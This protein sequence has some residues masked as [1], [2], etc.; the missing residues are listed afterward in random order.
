M[1]FSGITMA[2]TLIKEESFHV[3]LPD[4]WTKIQGTS[5]NIAWI[6]QSSNGN[7]RLTVS[8]HYF[9]KEP[10]LNEIKKSIESYILIRQKSSSEINSG[11]SI[12]PDELKEYPAAITNIFF[13]KGP[14]NRN[15]A[16]KT[17]ATKVGIANFYYESYE[18]NS[19]FKEKVKTIL[20]TTGFAS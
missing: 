11:I 10:S 3:R 9:A 15:A 1:F 6:Y 13:E 5:D 20:S 2:E 4:N 14:K 7:E 17:V 16:N 12:S 19:D 18:E 8:I